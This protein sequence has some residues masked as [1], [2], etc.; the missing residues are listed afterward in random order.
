M[1]RKLLRFGV[2]FCGVCAVLIAALLIFAAYLP[3]AEKVRFGATYS[4][5]YA[6]DLGMDPWWTYKE[7]VAIGI[8]DWRIPVY[9]DM[10]ERREGAYDFRLY[11]KILKDAEKNGSRMIL[12]VGRRVPRWPECHEPSWVRNQKSNLKSQKLLKFVAATVKR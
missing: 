10:V 9:W 1:M 11:D 5:K 2:W 8:R 12:V 4:V 3:G 7:L 6:R